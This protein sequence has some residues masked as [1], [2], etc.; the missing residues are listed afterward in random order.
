M[1]TDIISISYEGEEPETR[2]IRLFFVPI[3]IENDSQTAE[4]H[5]PEHKNDEI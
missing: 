1:Y 2:N 4:F 3:N 5:P